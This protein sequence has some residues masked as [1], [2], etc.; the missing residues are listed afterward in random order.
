MMN[1]DVSIHHLYIANLTPNRS[2]TLYRVSVL[3]RLQSF[4]L[5]KP[6]N[7]KETTFF[8]KGLPISDAFDYA[9]ATAGERRR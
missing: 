9:L 7:K 8:P 5:S 3:A 1:K 2:Y 6:K 4:N